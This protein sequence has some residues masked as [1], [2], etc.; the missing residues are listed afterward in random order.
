MRC[1]PS[2]LTTSWKESSRHTINISSSRKPQREQHLKPLRY[3]AAKSKEIL[4]VWDTFVRTEER[5]RV[6]DP[7]DPRVTST[8]HARRRP[9]TVAWTFERRKDHQSDPSLADS[10][11]VCNHNDRGKSMAK[12]PLVP[13]RFR[14]KVITSN[15]IIYARKNDLSSL[16]E[17][18]ETG[19]CYTRD[20]QHRRLTTMATKQELTQH[21]PLNSGIEG[22]HALLPRRS[23]HARMHARTPQHFPCP[24]PQT[25]RLG[26]AE[27]QVTNVFRGRPI[28]ITQKKLGMR[29]TVTELYGG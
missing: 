12:I 10:F 27:F 21:P 11:P 20:G 4:Q 19:L 9:D 23:T 5:Y 8:D 2:P 25:T 22:T 17:R 18:N 6:I 13:I 14:G 15:C 1:H 26:V 29:T 24:K 7:G 28:P 16:R 3:D